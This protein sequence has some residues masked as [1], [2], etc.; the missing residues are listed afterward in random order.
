VGS[1]DC[2]V[3][4]M[5]D[6]S[7]TLRRWVY[8]SSMA[9][10]HDVRQRGV[11]ERLLMLAVAHAR[12]IFGVKHM[13]LHVEELNGAA[14]RLYERAGFV[15]G[16]V[17]DSHMSAMDRMLRLV[18]QVP[19]AATLYMRSLSLLAEGVMEVE[20]IGADEATG[21]EAPSRQP[22]LSMRAP[23]EQS[24]AMHHVAERLA[25]QQVA[26]RVHVSHSMAL[27]GTADVRAQGAAKQLDR[28]RSS[29]RVAAKRHVA[30]ASESRAP[31]GPAL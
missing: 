25:V 16:D 31:R 2:S 7:L 21:A 9:V 3:H 5:F 12:N 29:P 28:E 6:S 20:G 17:D 1:V 10:R 8:V 15:R 30:A 13:F 24:N 26:R 14:L 23:R 4:E 22:R 27:R 19:A 11:G 18:L